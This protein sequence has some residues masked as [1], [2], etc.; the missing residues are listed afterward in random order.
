MNLSLNDSLLT[1]SDIDDDD[2]DF[3]DTLVVEIC[4]QDTRE[5]LQEYANTTV[6]RKK[7]NRFEPIKSPLDEDTTSATDS[8]RSSRVPSPVLVARPT[9]QGKNFQKLRSWFMHGCKMADLNVLNN[10]LMRAKRDIS[11]GALNENDLNRVLSE[12]VTKNGDTLLHMAVAIGNVNLIEWLMDNDASPCQRNK[13]NLTPY[14]VTND[15][16]IREVFRSFAFRNPDKFDYAKAQIPVTTMSKE[17]LLQKRK[18]Q[19]RI[20]KSRDKEKRLA[21]QKEDDQIR[22]FQQ[23]SDREKVIVL[24]IWFFIKLIRCVTF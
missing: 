11:N 16:T 18:E 7:K 5:Q 6:R 8:V 9:C 24:N 20:K 3:D 13:N 22:Q 12:P 10:Y 15:K 14:T 17:D 19:K 4:E 1:N 21:K 23:L 2:D